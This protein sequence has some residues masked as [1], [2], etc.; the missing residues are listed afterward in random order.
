VQSIANMV[1]AMGN[2]QYATG[3]NAIEFK[4]FCSN[5]DLDGTLLDV[6]FDEWV[7]YNNHTQVWYSSSN[8]V[9]PVLKREIK[10]EKPSYLFIIGMYDWVYNFKPLMF[11]AGV[12]KIISVRGMLHPG[13]LSQKTFKKK[14]YLRLWKILG[15]HKG[16][17]ATGNGPIGKCPPGLS[18]VRTGT[19]IFHATDEAEKKYI[20]QVFGNDAHVI[21]AANFPNALQVQSV[22]EKKTGFLKLASIALI[23]PMKNILMVL[24]AIG[25][26]QL[27]VGKIEYDIYGPVKDKNYWQQC[28]SVIKTLPANVTVNYHGDIAP[29]KITNALAASHI[30]ILPS[31]SENFGHS[32]YEA[33]S[34]ARPVITSNNT[35]WLNLQDAKAGINVSL[36]DT[37]ELISAIAFFA[38]MNQEELETWSMGAR[39]CADGAVDIEQIRRQY[40]EMFG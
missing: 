30:F 40:E 13:A 9:L 3:N 17:L 34:A 21:V 1:K 12:K 24:E 22:M 19:N 31:K 25:S 37:T 4:I 32:L 6:P 39:A 14:I 7:T 33:L 26:K 15:L 23:S 11:T 16:K 2:W 27:A 18:A 10:K 8:N 35:P 5:K 20:E 38:A 28:R 29:D 36:N